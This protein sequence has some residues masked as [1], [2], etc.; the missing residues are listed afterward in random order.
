MSLSLY[1]ISAQYQQA[2]LRLADSELDDET[3]NDTLEAMDGEVEV[4]ARNVAYFIRN[5][6]ATAD[7]IKSAEKA[8]ADR[9]KAFDNRVARLK[10]YL[11][12]NMEACGMTKIECPEFSLTI[13]RNPPSVIIDDAGRIPSELYVYPD[14]PA[15]YPD[16]TAIK[17]RLNA[18][19][20][21]EG[22]HLESGTRLDIK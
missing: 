17:E 19:E 12:Q 9:R 20:V 6:E 5:I 14:Q 2:F 11:K 18:G 21:I 16:K 10:E 22:C 4:K 8:M 13:K 1:E 7:A 15:P 3:I